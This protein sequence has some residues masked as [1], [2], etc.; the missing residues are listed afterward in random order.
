MPYVSFIID[1]DTP[2]ITNEYLVQYDNSGVFTDA[3]V[4]AKYAYTKDMSIKGEWYYETDMTD[5]SGLEK[6]TRYTISD[7]ASIDSVEMTSAGTYVGG[8]IVLSEITNGYHIRMKVGSNTDDEVVK[9]NWKIACQESDGQHLS[10]E[11]EIVLNVD[12]KKPD[13]I[14]EGDFYNMGQAFTIAGH[15]YRKVTNENG[16]FTFGTQA[17][18]D[19]VDR[20]SQTGVKRIAFYF[21]RDINTTHQLYDVM[22]KKGSSGNAVDGYS[23]LT[24]EDGL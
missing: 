7:G 9:Q 22:I 11:S 4:T 14:E 20:V 1:K 12:N 10:G 16:F 2:Q 13:V 5:E 23:S 21:T 15:D 18:E 19:A 6:V 24:Y 3:H 17:K 8:D